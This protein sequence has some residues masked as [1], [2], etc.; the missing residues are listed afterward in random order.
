[1]QSETRSSS[2]EC[3]SWVNDDNF[4]KENWF[5]FSAGC[6]IRII[7]HVGISQKAFITSNLSERQLKTLNLE[8]KK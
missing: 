8:Q 7:Y 2:Y 6:T 5:T 3:A 1:M 4:H